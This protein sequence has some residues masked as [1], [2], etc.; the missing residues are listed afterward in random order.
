MTSLVL[1][2]QQQQQQKKKKK[3]KFKTKPDDRVS[4]LLTCVGRRYSEAICG[5]FRIRGKIKACRT[6]R[7]SRSLSECDSMRLCGGGTAK[8]KKGR[9][10]RPARSIPLPSHVKGGTKR[11]GHQV[12]R[13]STRNRRASP[14]HAIA[15]NRR[16]P[17]R[18]GCTRSQRER[19]LRH[20]TNELCQFIF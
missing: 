18:D 19:R 13:R 12:T 17:S 16:S 20:A 10:K 9:R 3:A 11:T 2:Q 14:V 5:C 7:Q 4:R 6:V 8:G 15:F 1:R